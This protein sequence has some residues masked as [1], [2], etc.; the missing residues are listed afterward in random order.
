MHSALTGT[1]SRSWGV[2]RPSAAWLAVP[3][4]LWLILFGLA[5]IAFMLAMSTWTSDIFG[6]TATW[7]LDNYRRFWEE[8]LYISVLF[9]TVRVAL[10][11][12]V[13]SLLISYPLAWFLAERRGRAKAILL[14]LV[15]VPFWTSYLIRTFVWLPILGRN[16]IINDLLLRIGIINQPLEWLLYNEGTIYLGLVYVYTLFMT[17]PVYVSL[18]RLDRSLIAAA[19]DLGARPFRIFL[20]I[21][22]PLSMPGVLSGSVMVFLL[23]AGA[24]VTPQLLGGPSAIMFGNLIAAQFLNN[25]NWAFGAALSMILIVVVMLFVFVVG[26]R[27]GLQRVFLGEGV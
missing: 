26:R 17:L 21:V 18:E 8:P 19:S 14:I 10:T 3:A 15:F 16:G 25:N 23:S 13:L 5:P 27:M 24:F 6:M 9:T 1:T 7:N 12:T 20:R 11:C 4:A 22:L 2:R